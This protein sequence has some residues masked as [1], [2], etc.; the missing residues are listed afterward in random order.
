MAKYPVSDISTA[1]VKILEKYFDYFFYIEYEL[2]GFVDLKFLREGKRYN[3]SVNLIALDFSQQP[4]YEFVNLSDTLS[5]LRINSFSGLDKQKY[6]SFLDSVFFEISSKKVHNLFIDVSDN[7]GGNSMY[8]NLLLPYLGVETLKTHQS[9]KLKTSR[10]TKKYLRS[11]YVKWYLYPLYP[12]AYFSKIGRMLFFKKNGLIMNLD[13]DE[14]TLKAHVNPY[15]NK[16]IL[17]TSND[18]YSAAADLVVSLR[19]ADRCVVVGDTLSQPYMGFID[20]VLI[21]LENSQ[22]QASVSFKSYEYIGANTENKFLGIEPDILLRHESFTNRKAFYR[23]VV[24][25]LK[26]SLLK[27]RGTHS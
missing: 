23:G 9:Y 15:K 14:S 24:D 8:A 3:Q 5:V 2:E 1:R 25:V 22:L 20:K 21:L 19:A 7:G 18:T 13:T 27:K 10:P 26:L 16:V 12:F 17:L 4:K 6:V 11:A